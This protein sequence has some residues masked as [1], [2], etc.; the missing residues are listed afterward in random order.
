VSFCSGSFEATAFCRK[1]GGCSNRGAK[2]GG[3][4]GATSRGRVPRFRR[5]QSAQRSQPVLLFLVK[6]ESLQIQI[7]GVFDVVGTV[8]FLKWW[9][10]ARSFQVTKSNLA[11]HLL[12]VLCLVALQTFFDVHLRETFRSHGSYVVD[13]WCDFSSM[14]VLVIELN[15]FHIGA[16]AALFSWR[17]DRALFLNGPQ[18]GFELRICEKI[19]DKPYEILPQRWTEYIKARREKCTIQ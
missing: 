12:S 16:G 8:C 13:F 10:S 2:V 1:C 4:D 6:Q 18:H 9:R 3:E 14:E 15:P 5:Q 11:K 7:V 19:E 17:Q